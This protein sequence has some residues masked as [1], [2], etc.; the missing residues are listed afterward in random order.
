MHDI[1]GTEAWKD[2]QISSPAEVLLQESWLTLVAQ[3]K[4][5]AEEEPI[6][7]ATDLGRVFRILQVGATTKAKA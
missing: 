7:S 2:A 5:W 4:E 3:R 6:C 1:Q